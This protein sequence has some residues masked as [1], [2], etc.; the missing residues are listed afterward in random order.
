MSPLLQKK[1]NNK[2]AIFLI[3][4]FKI[5][6]FNKHIVSTD[7]SKLW[8]HS[9]YVLKTVFMYFKITEQYLKY[10]FFLTSAFCKFWEKKK[11]CHINVGWIEIGKNINIFF[12]SNNIL[13]SGIFVLD[14]VFKKSSVANSRLW[15]LPFVMLTL[16]STWLL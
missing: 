13:P 9:Y 5:L 11:K 6:Q 15:F 1:K 12:F 4:T 16:F 2:K 14:N 8:M 7:L 10:I 3:V